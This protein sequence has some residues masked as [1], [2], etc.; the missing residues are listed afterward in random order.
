MTQGR[1]VWSIPIERDKIGRVYVNQ[2]TAAAPLLQVPSRKRPTTELDSI[3]HALSLQRLE[4]GLVGVFL[5]VAPL[6]R[7]EAMPFRDLPHSTRICS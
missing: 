1:P 6:T 4:H 2:P 5:S 7:L 3:T